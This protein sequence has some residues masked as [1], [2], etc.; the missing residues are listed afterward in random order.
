[1]PYKFPYLDQSHRNE[2]IGCNF[3]ILAEQKL[4]NKSALAET[5]R[6]ATTVQTLSDCEC[7]VGTHPLS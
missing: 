4:A 2:R 6:M 7:P 5:Q 3:F 1:M